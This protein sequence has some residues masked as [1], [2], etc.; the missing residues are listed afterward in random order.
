MDKG[1]QNLNQ[2]EMFKSSNFSLIELMK[3]TNPHN[4][5]QQSLN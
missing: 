3:K 1:K 2:I 4:L 5:V